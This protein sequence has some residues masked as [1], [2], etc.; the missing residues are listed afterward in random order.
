MFLKDF[1]VFKIKLG[2]GGNSVSKGDAYVLERFWNDFASF[3]PFHGATD[4]ES[5]LSG[6]P[7]EMS[8]YFLKCKVD[9]QA[10]RGVIRPPFES[11][12]GNISF[13]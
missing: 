4:R 11:G 1:E 10:K 8:R 5:R 13:V 6:E 3:E 7:G 9:T 12:G 2:N